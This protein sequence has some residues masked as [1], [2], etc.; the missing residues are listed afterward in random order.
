MAGDRAPPAMVPVHNADWARTSDSEAHAM[1]CFRLC[2]RPLRRPPNES[3]RCAGENDAQENLHGIDRCGDAAG[4]GIIGMCLVASSRVIMRVTSKPLMSGITT[5]IRMR[6]GFSDF[7]LSMA[8][9]AVSANT[10]R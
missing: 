6:S 4:V 3:A 2:G 7:A 9:L 1:A 5:S 10:H 8:S